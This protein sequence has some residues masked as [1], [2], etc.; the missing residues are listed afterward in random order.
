MKTAIIILTAVGFAL[1]ILSNF[2]IT[3]IKNDKQEVVKAYFNHSTTAVVAGLM[4]IFGIL[5]LFADGICV[6]IRFL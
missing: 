3:Y 5:T 1:L 4:K 2:L 6:L